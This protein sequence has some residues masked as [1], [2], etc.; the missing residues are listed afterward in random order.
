MVAQVV[1]T[2]TNDTLASDPLPDEV[3]GSSWSYFVY[4][5]GGAAVVSLVQ[6]KRDQSVGDGIDAARIRVFNAYG[7]SASLVLGGITSNCYKCLIPRQCLLP[8]GSVTSEV[9]GVVVFLFLFLF[10]CLSPCSRRFLFRGCRR[11]G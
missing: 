6:D 8:A 11:P 10:L 4:S 9:R 1:D 5:D 7:G 2:V 3:D